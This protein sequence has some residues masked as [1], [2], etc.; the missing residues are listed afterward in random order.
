MS[1]APSTLMK[2]ERLGRWVSRL[3]LA[4]GFVFLYLPIVALVVYSFN[5]SPLATRW[6]G[7]TFEWFRKLAHDTEVLQG[8]WLS[9]KTAFFTACAAVVLVAVEGEK[10][11]A[12]NGLIYKAVPEVSR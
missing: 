12:R 9:L 1:A 6:A 11:L 8:L 2:H 7:F 5:D 10:W 3:W 4:G